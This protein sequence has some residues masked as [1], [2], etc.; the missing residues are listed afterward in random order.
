M[1]RRAVWKMRSDGAHITT[2]EHVR[3]PVSAK[4]V[5]SQDHPAVSGSST[6]GSVIES[7]EWRPACRRRVCGAAREGGVEQGLRGLRGL[8]SA[9]RPAPARIPGRPLITELTTP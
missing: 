1:Y 2:K 7:S 5:G 8:F 3:F 4:Q 9:Q 6:S